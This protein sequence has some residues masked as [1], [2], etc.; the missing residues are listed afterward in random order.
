LCYG[1]EHTNGLWTVKELYG[2]PKPPQILRHG[3]F[4]DN[5]PLFYLS[6]KSADLYEWPSHFPQDWSAN[7]SLPMFP[8]GVLTQY[9]IM[10]LNNPGFDIVGFENKRADGIESEPI[11]ICTECRF[12][13]P[14]STTKLDKAAIERK[15]DL[16][17]DQFYL[18]FKKGEQL[19][20]LT[21]KEE[22]LFL[23]V[24]AFR[25]VNNN[26]I[27]DLPQNTVVLNRDML[28]ALYTPSLAARPQ[29]ILPLQ[30]GESTQVPE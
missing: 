26:V 7:A 10:P 15:R 14:A 8:E 5:N 24:C 9:M 30:H 23:I 21:I 16:T 6:R 19:D 2:G 22:N 20:G 12:S 1:A 29:F 3:K 25:D 27:T 18:Y 4:I 11:I 17:V 28:K 13:D